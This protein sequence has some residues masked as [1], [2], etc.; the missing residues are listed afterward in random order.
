MAA[1]LA[2]DTAVRDAPARAARTGVRWLLLL[3][4]AFLVLAAF[5]VYPVVAIVVRA[6]TDPALGLGNFQAVW[7]DPTM[8]RVLLRTVATALVVTVVTLALAYPYAYLMTVVGARGR[9]V[10]LALVLLPFWTSLMARNF[11]WIVLL[12]DGG[13]IVRVTSALGLTDRALL[14]TETGVAIGMMQVLL[15]YMVLPLYATMSGIDRRL[16]DAAGGLGAPR[17]TAFRRVYLPL[18]MPGVIAGSTLVFVLSLGFYVTPRLLGSPKQSLIAQV[19]GTK[20][21]KLL[22]FGG[23]GALSLI[24]LVITAL[25]LLLVGRV[26]KPAAA[27]GL[28]TED[29]R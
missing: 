28:D 29:G 7:D 14:G 18:S 17:F 10:M 8:T 27:L 6:F 23:A 5:F 22:D 12:Q 19:I 1:D 25:L 13:P 21:E 2:V 20:V 4:P 9:A 26:A 3:A 16:L 15:P 24:L 11:A